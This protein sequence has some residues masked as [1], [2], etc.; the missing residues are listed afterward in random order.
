MIVI[1]SF[2]HP[3]D[4][5]AKTSPNMT[6]VR[7][8]YAEIQQDE[9]EALRSIYMEDF[10]EE[11]VRMGAWNVSHHVSVKRQINIPLEIG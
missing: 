8:N 10:E 2:I 9:V 1:H 6:P 3:N 4:S 11:E 7:T 5:H